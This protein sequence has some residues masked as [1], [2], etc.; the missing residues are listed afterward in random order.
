[1]KQI[2]FLSLSHSVFYNKMLITHTHKHTKMGE[3]KR[4]DIFTS[5]KY[6]HA[7]TKKISFKPKR[8]LYF[9]SDYKSWIHFGTHK[10]THTSNDQ[11]KK[12]LITR[13]L[14]FDYRKK[15][16]NTRARSKFL[17]CK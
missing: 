9:I 6:T 8:N 7:H 15:K 16:K 5:H 17:F 13:Q 11:P 12:T 4:N 2:D 10:H 1:M 14:A 3:T